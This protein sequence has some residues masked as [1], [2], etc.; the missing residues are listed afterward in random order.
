[1]CM[2]H[3]SAQSLT[4]DNKIKYPNLLLYWVQHLAGCAIGLDLQT[5]VVGSDTVIEIAPIAQAEAL[6]QLKILIESW[7][8]GMQYPLP[9]AC[10]T[11][12]AWLSAAPDK[13]LDAAQSAYEGDDWNRGEVDYDAYLG[14]FFPSFISLT[15][16]T[17][18]EGFVAWADTLYQ[19]AFTQIK[20]QGAPA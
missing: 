16:E 19:S 1:N 2:L 14:R 15:P 17:A 8:L 20:L 4:K 13:A 7:Q 3:L 12:F 5:R 6:A 18:S 9:V 10:K 11:A